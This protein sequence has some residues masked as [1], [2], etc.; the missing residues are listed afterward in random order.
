MITITKG[1]TM[2]TI[3][4]WMIENTKSAF[5][6]SQKLSTKFWKTPETKEMRNKTFKSSKILLFF[7][8]IKVDVVKNVKTVEN[9]W[10]C[11]NCVFTYSSFYAFHHVNPI[12]F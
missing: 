12:F 1:V 7:K 8:K 10:L 4:I 9:R 11:E 5:S 3:F 6:K 2:S